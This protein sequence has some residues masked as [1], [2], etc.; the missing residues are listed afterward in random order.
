MAIAF[1]SDDNTDIFGK[2]TDLNALQ[3][4]AVSSGD[5]PEFSLV[6]ELD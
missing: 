2:R 6:L 4:A 3:V 1:R 5:L